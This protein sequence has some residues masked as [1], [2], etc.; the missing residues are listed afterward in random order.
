[1][2][3]IQAIQASH[4]M[5]AS[6][7]MVATGQQEEEKKEGILGMLLGGLASLIFGKGGLKGALS[8]LGKKFAGSTAGK[9][10]RSFASKTALPFLG[11][12][13]GMAAT[14]Y[15]LFGENGNKLWGAETVAMDALKIGKAVAGNADERS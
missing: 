2:E 15:Q 13:A 3:E 7:Q 1:M 9:A 4:Q 11:E 5:N 8:A 14:G 6:N 12:A 10:I